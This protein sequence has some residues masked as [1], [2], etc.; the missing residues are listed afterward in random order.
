MKR[1]AHGEPPKAR[2]RRAHF[3]SP[4]LTN[5][6]CSPVCPWMR[7][8]VLRGS[9]YCLRSDRVECL[10]PLARTVM[11]RT[12]PI[13][14]SLSPNVKVPWSGR[15]VAVQ[16]RIRLQRSF[17]IRSHSYHGYV[18]RIDGI[19][20]GAARDFL[21]AVGEGAHAKHR[22]MVGMLVSGL[23]VAIEDPTREIA[24]FYKTSGIKVVENIEE[25]TPTGP[26]FHGLPPDL[27]TYRRRGHRRLDVRTFESK[28]TTCI[29]GCLMPVEMII[30]QWNPSKVRNRFE[31][32][33][34]GPKNC[35]LYHAG[36][37]RKVPG[38]KGLSYTEEDWV[39]EEA[40]AH[41]EEDE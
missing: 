7:C 15:I 18:L 12:I 5:T 13:L 11:S 39:D 28:C 33:C 1:V 25:S 2:P 22:F 6:S 30:D 4:N 35:S 32:F 38:R 9:V 14:P 8:L 40:T 3:V 29:W 16:P 19:C 24:E 20:G 31:T 23:S 17:D 21:I 41:R 10:F 27:E 34:Y 37:A 36:P 26:P